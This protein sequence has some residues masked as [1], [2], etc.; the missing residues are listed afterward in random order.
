MT[1]IKRVSVLS[2]GTVA[3]RP[4]HVQS[5]GTPALWW[6][7]TSRRWARPRPINVYVIEH[8]GGLVLFDTGQDRRSVTDPSYFPT[9]VAGLLNRRLAR[10]AIAPDQTLTAQLAAIGHDV[11]DVHTAV[12]SHLHIDHVG[13]LPELTHATIVTS[14]AER[15]T[16]DR[17][18]AETNGLLRNHILHPGLH[19][20][21]LTPQP[22]DD[23]SLAP[24][25]AAHDLFDD[26]SLILLPTPGHTPGS[27]SLLIRRPGFPPL[28]LVGD[29]TF[30]IHLMENEHVP[31]L[32]RRHTSLATTRRIN[33]LRQTYPD[34]VVLPAHDPGAADRLAA[35]EQPDRPQRRI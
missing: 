8:V 32:G 21:L 13:G 30:D 12:L 29:L 26:G 11:A 2:T 6:L 3:I 33:A 1:S 18:F 24:F 4:Q 16:L 5:D 19:W 34:L 28:L 27:L 23:P 31:G 20:E 35:A 17:P 9:G 14:H 7:L 10:F 15:R 25:T 22:T